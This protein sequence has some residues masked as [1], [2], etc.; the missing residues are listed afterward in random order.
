MSL[1]ANEVY[2]VPAETERVA[3][4]AFP[5]GNLYLRLYDEFGSLFSDSEFQKLCPKMGQPAFS[6]MRLALITLMQFAEGLTDRGAAEAVRARIDW[7]FIL[8]L[9]LTDSGF[10]HTVLSE[11]RTRLVEAGLEYQLFNLLLNKFKAVELIKPRSK[12]RTDATHVLAAVRVLNRLERVGETLR[13]TLNALATIA[14]QWLS[15]QLPAEWWERYSQKVDNYKLPRADSD[16]AALGATI[17][18]DGFLLLNLLAQETEL[19]WLKSLPAVQVLERVWY[20]HF[21]VPP[22]KVKLLDKTELPPSADQ[23]VSPYDLSAR[24]CQHHH[25]SWVGYKIHLT[26]TCEEDTPNLITDVQITP[27][28]TPDEKVT[29]RVYQNLA[30][31]ALLP[32]KHYVDGGYTNAE[33][34][35]KAKEEYNVTIVGPLCGETSWQARAG[36]GFSQTDFKV[37]WEK[38]K[39][40][41]PQGKESVEWKPGYRKGMDYPQIRVVFSVQDCGECEFREKCTKSKYKRREVVLQA[42]THYEALQKA[43]QCQAGLEFK[44]EYALRSGVEGT[45]SQAV[46]TTEVRYARYRGLSKVKL[47]EAISAAALNLV[48]VGAWLADYRYDKAKPTPFAALKAVA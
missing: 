21:S 39:V 35:V 1:Q 22:E 40:T 25:K 2:P 19:S 6:P 3:R 42:Q 26:E 12:A 7:K 37:D 43:R 16:R 20:A 47:E 30:A 33:T 29:L 24:Y 28:T 11:F 45:I 4:A 31:K 36:E 9:E 18:E 13:A 41:C 27:A 46:R 8:A 17:G 23:I 34:V 15:S 32:S 38:Q 44:R 10:D 14:P 5:K 48:R